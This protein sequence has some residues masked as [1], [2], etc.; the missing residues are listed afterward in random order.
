MVLRL[1]GLRFTGKSGVMREYGQLQCAI[2]S[3]L[4]IRGLVSIRELSTIARGPCPYTALRCPSPET[5]DSNVRLTDIKQQSCKLLSLSNTL[6]LPALV[7]HIDSK[8]PHFKT[9]T[10]KLTASHILSAIRYQCEGAM[11]G[12][13]G[14]QWCSCLFWKVRV[15]P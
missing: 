3:L 13:V 10:S 1:P 8:S 4:M 12:G 2:D 9:V 5:V 14:W 6:A 11:V 7:Q 15:F